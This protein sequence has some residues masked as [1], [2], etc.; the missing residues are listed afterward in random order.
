MAKD[1]VGGVWSY[2][3][4]LL[5]ALASRHCEVLL[6]TMGAS[7]SSS[8]RAEVAGIP[9]LTIRESLYKLEWMED[10]WAHVDA[11]GNWLME[12]A[13]DFRPEIVHLN[14]FSHGA[15]P[16]TAPVLMVGHSCVLSVGTLAAKSAS[17]ASAGRSGG[18][19]HPYHAQRDANLLW[20]LS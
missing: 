2:T 16:W 6:A 9:R 5:R 19:T 18:C 8:Q 7:L 4:E 3:S 17:G 15:L 1:T 12:L 14:T 11:S 10:P 20:P 13:R